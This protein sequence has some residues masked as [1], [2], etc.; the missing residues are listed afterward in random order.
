MGLAKPG[1]GMERGFLEEAV[2]EMVWRAAALGRG[3]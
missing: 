3:I 1:E 2:N